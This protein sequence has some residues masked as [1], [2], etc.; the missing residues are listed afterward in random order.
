MKTTEDIPA[1]IPALSTVHNNSALNPSLSSSTT[2]GSLGTVLSGSAISDIPARGIATM[3]TVSNGSTHADTAA[4][5][6]TASIS[7][8]RNYKEVASSE[9]NGSRDCSITDKSGSDDNQQSSVTIAKV[10]TT[11]SSRPKLSQLPRKHWFSSRFCPA[12][13]CCGISTDPSKED[14]CVELVLGALIQSD[15]SDDEKF[16]KTL[17]VPRQAF[18]KLLNIIEPDLIRKRTNWCVPLAPTIRLCVYLYYAGHDSF[19]QQLSAQF[20]IDLSTASGIIKCVSESIT[21]RMENWIAF[22]RHVLCIL[23]YR[24]HLRKTITFPVMWLP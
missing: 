8:H 2:R 9:T 16:R 15:H 14:D 18:W 1:R 24:V 23:N 13:W 20:G 3:N 21:S 11:L 10:S 22:P 5:G 7:T 12:V 4:M 19:L 17:R 6:T